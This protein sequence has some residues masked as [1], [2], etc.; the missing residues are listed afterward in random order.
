[1]AAD[2]LRDQYLGWKGDGVTRIRGDFRREWIES[3]SDRFDLMHVLGDV[4]GVEQEDL[5]ALQETGKPLV[6]TYAGNSRPASLSE[7]IL[8]RGA[9]RIVVNSH[10]AHSDANEIHGRQATLV[11][12]SHV[13]SLEAMGH[14]APGRRIPP[15]TIG[16]AL[17][18]LSPDPTGETIVEVMTR[19]A[20]ES[21][22]F[23]ARVD[24]EAS[25]FE[26]ESAP[27]SLAPLLTGLAR[28]GQLDLRVHER[29]GSLEISDFA[30][31]VDM[32]VVSSWT[33]PGIGWIEACRDAGT[34]VIAPAGRDSDTLRPSFGFRIFPTGAC[35]RDD[36][37]SAF[38]EAQ[39]ALQRGEMEPVGADRRRHHRRNIASLHSRI[40][41]EVLA[42]RAPLPQQI[43]V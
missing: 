4:E 24:V 20:R 39:R 2:P 41:S 18:S 15:F 27:G 35:N 34:A 9:D 32:A 14:L 38:D 12:H 23:R 40:F 17:D 1:M 3:N 37:G 21:S 7:T 28:R 13:L 16:F 8:M 29:F 42:N 36:L 22:C 31:G 25:S 11:P 43:A 33:G 5:T 30:V 19:M 6:Y 10:Q 26:P